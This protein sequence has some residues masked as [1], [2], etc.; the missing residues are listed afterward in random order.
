MSPRVWGRGKERPQPDDGT[1]ALLFDL[2][3]RRQVSPSLRFS[4][5]AQAQDWTFWP[6]LLPGF[7][8]NTPGGV[9]PEDRRR[10]RAEESDQANDL[11]QGEMPLRSRDMLATIDDAIGRIERIVADGGWPTIPGTR[12]IRPGDDDE[13]IPAVRRI[14][15][16]WGDMRSQGGY[17]SYNFDGELEAGG[18][19][20]PGAARLAGQRP[21]RSAD[22]AGHEHPG[23]ARLAQ[24][25]LNQQRIRDLIGQRMEDK[26][27]L[28]NVPAF[29][30]EAVER[31]NV[32]QRHRVIAGKPERQT[33]SVTGDHPRAQFLPVLAGA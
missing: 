14:L 29:Q 5:P 3:L 13:R 25:R 30:L 27:V 26:Y 31:H 28:V 8:S 21:R 22:A 12:M 24:L 20:L 10:R 18:P 11:R 23:P 32:E 19:P 7:A 4:T 6:Q 1:Q 2:R 17:G 9:P 33:P 16:L 15:V